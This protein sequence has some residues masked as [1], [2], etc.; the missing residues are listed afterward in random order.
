MPFSCTRQ[1]GAHLMAASLR[2]LGRACQMV[3]GNLD[4]QLAKSRLTQALNIGFASRHIR[5][6]KV[7]S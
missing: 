6:T 1:V 5:K 3:Y 4:W 7:R 2:Q